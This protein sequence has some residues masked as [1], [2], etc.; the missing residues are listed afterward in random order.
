M[1]SLQLCL[2][3][4]LVF[5]NWFGVISVVCCC[6]GLLT[7]LDL[8]LCLWFAVLVFCALLIVRLQCLETRLFGVSGISRF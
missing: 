8:F 4:N 5:L 3:F 1:A 2:L 7:S 6:W